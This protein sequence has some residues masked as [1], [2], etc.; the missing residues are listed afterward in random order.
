MVMSQS[1]PGSVALKRMYGPVDQVRQRLLRATAALDRAGVPYAVVGGNAVADWVTR[2]DAAAVRFTQ[3]VDLLLRRTDLDSAST[4]LAAAGFVR[5][6]AAGMDC[7]LDGATAKARDAVHIVFAGE[8]V[9]PDYLLPAP[10]VSE[11]DTSSE[12]RVLALDALVRMKLTSFRR[13]DQVHLQDMLAVGLIDASWCR[14]FPT[15]L[16]LRLQHLIDTPEE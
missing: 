11:S 10:D 3:E 8:K 2:V 13:K 9:R 14:R 12:F 1:M 5:M 7:V 6:H 15:E 16:S 4:A